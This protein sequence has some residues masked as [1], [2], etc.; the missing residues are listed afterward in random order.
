MTQEYKKLKVTLP[1]GEKFILTQGREHFLYL[2]SEENW[3]GFFDE[4][5]E[6]A[7]ESADAKMFMRY[8]MRTAVE[9]EVDEE[10]EIEI[11]EMLWEYLNPECDEA[12]I[13]MNRI[14]HTD[15]LGMAGKYQPWLISRK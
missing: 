1:K 5:L 15:N 6:L 9:V 12:V 3:E 10:N 2:F 11:P 7:K 14:Q 13:T 8:L 4:L